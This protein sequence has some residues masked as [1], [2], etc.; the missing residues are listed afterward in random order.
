MPEGKAIERSRWQ[1]VL[2]LRPEL[3][4]ALDPIG[5]LLQPTLGA[6]PRRQRYLVDGV[7]M[8][9]SRAVWWSLGG[10]VSINLF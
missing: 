1:P 10:A 6:T 9:S 5:F 2:A 8:L 3:A 7:E 4:L